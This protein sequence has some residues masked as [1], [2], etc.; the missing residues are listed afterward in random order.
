M[1][2]ASEA[3]GAESTNAERAASPPLDVHSAAETERRRVT[4]IRR[5]AWLA[6]LL[7]CI[8]TFAYGAYAKYGRATSLDYY[9]VAPGAI[10][11][12]KGPGLLD[13]VN[14]VVISAKTLGRLTSLPVK[15]NEIVQP[16]EVVA[17]DEADEAADQLASIRAEAIAAREHVKEAESER[18]R[19]RSVYQ[20]ASLDFERRSTLASR[21]VVT[22]GALDTAAAALEQ[23]KAELVLAQNG[24]DRAQAQADA[25]AASERVMAAR[26]ANATLTSPIGGLVVSRDRNVGDLVG[27]AQKILEIVDPRSIVVRARFDES[28]MNQIAVGQKATVRFISEPAEVYEG[29]VVELYHLV[30]Q[31]TREFTADVALAILPHNW[32]LGQ[33]ATVQVDV[34][35]NP[36]D[37][38]VPIALL[39]QRDGQAG[40]W[41]YHEGRARWIQVS[42]GYSAGGAVQITAELKAGDTILQPEDLH[43]YQRV[44]L[45]KPL[46]D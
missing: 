26:L 23:A 21:G 11:K 27:P 1:E 13:A 46:E 34:P 37:I 32:A 12:I 43:E 28:V 40:L 22:Q 9:T 18:D 4:K 42:L 8:A 17:A 14:R 36:R 20:K 38:L 29:T 45:A 33:R 35:Q 7:M 19:A 24:I 25:A 44:D 41:L 31:E 5:A 15:L 10:L 39:D 3:G 6:A 16:N 2:P 30:D